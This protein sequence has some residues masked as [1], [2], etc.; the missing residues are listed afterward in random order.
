MHES[1]GPPVH[2]RMMV[3]RSLR[4]GMTQSFVNVLTWGNTQPGA[5]A[6]WDECVDEA[7]AILPP[8][9]SNPGFAAG[10][11]ITQIRTEAGHHSE[12]M[13]AQMDDESSLGA[14]MKRMRSVGDISPTRAVSS[15][16]FSARS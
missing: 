12:V 14:G 13:P 10:F 9:A 2:L 7:Y 16:A 15:P 5:W 11:N 3:T 4:M 1:P 8:E 6:W